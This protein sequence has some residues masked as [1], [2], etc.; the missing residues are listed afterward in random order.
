MDS[1]YP[2][3]DCP[4]RGLDQV[5]IGKSKHPAEKNNLIDLKKPDI[6]VN[7]PSDQF[8]GVE[9]VLV[10]TTAAQPGVTILINP[11]S[12]ALRNSASADPI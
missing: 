4:R 2:L 10:L 1:R 5:T 9:A 8:T 7:D 3:I 11:I 6:F 12:F